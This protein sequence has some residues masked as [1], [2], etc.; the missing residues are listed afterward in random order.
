[1]SGN[2]FAELF[3][4]T[5]FFLGIVCG[6]IYLT[7]RFAL[8]RLSRFRIP[9]G[10]PRRSL[11]VVDQVVLGRGKVLCVVRAAGTYL[12]LGTTDKEIRTLCELRREDVEAI[13][14]PEPAGA[15]T[16]AHDPQ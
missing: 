13:Y 2:G 16:G 7:I 8:P 6:L 12:L 3:F 15:T 14:G 10:R 9:T 1:M 5:L 11:A 4:R